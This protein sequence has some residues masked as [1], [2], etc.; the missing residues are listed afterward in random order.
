MSDN[1]FFNF[2][3]EMPK[4]YQEQIKLFCKTSSSGGTS[5]E[6]EL[7]PFERQIDFWYCAF[8]LAVKKN[9]A[10]TIE[11]DTYNAISASIL[12]QDSYRITHIQAVFLSVFNDLE[13]LSEHRKVFDFALGMA[14]SGIPLLLQILSDS[15]GRPI[16]NIL[17]KLEELGSLG[18]QS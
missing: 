14:N 10:P 11:K 2:N 3:V 5:D 6:Y 18:E 7:K 12:S 13:A 16:W 9:V 1:P 8:L 17:D 15:D 4:K